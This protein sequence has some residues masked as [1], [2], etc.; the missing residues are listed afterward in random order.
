MEEKRL[1]GAVVRAHGRFFWVKTKDNLLQCAVR[2]TIKTQAEARLSPVV[3]GDYVDLEP[4]IDL[5]SQADLD[6][7]KPHAVIVNVHPRRTK[8]SRPKRGREEMEQIVAANIEQ[9]LIITS[10]AR[11]QFKA[12]IIDR[13][14][15]CAGKGGLAPV[16][17]MNKIDLEHD[18]D[19]DRLSR[20]YGSIDVPF[21]TTSV[22]EMIRIEDAIS[23][24]RNKISII[25]GQSGVGK[26]SLLNVIEKDLNLKVG[27]I[28]KATQK[29]IHTTTSVRMYPLSLGGYVVDTPGLRY[30]GLWNLDMS[31]LWRHF[32]EIEARSGDCRFRNC[33]H[34]AE[35]DCAVKAAVENGDIFVERYESYLKIFEELQT[36]AF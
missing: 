16:V 18:L 36:N 14:L 2:E 22:T 13:F 17:V 4:L 7:R 30:L 19:L 15:I 21:L 1:T 26:S 35:P 27:D 20:I 23:F 33:R 11:P 3:V 25:V 12:G 8:F 28:S 31:D 9:M 32:P 24:L 29:G 6:N 10:V 5:E 34:M